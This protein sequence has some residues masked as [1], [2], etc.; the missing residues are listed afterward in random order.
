MWQLG[1]FW[2]LV[3]FAG[4]VIPHYNQVVA[5]TYE[6]IDCLTFDKCFELKYICPIMGW[7]ILGLQ[8]F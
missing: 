8:L 6:C 3:Q 4:K 2:L 1:G 5:I 7:F